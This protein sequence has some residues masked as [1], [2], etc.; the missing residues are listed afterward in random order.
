M[1]LLADA[2]HNLWSSQG[3]KVGGFSASQRTNRNPFVRPISLHELR[4]K[5]E[6]KPL[7]GRH[8]RLRERPRPAMRV[9][10]TH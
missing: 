5:V 7:R 8:A 3:R 9:H 1:R 10:R 6:T 4:S 2:G